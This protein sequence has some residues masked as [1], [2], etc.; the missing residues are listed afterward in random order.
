MQKV[1]TKTR[2]AVQQQQISQIQIQRPIPPNSNN[3][4][5]TRT[6]HFTQ[7]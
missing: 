5:I 7:L 3:D 4:E 6:E 2:E 1:R